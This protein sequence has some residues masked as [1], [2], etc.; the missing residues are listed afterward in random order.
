[1]PLIFSFIAFPD[2]MLADYKL[3]AFGSVNELGTGKPMCQCAD[4]KKASQL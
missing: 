2:I 3:R 1:M 4:I